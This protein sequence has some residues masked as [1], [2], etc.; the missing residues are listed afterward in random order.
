MSHLAETTRIGNRSRNAGVAIVIVNWRGW[1]DTIECL[2]SVFR[3][4]SEDFRVIVC[5][6][7]SGDG[8]LDAIER[9]AEGH[10]LAK[11]GN[12]E[13]T[14]CSSPPVQKPIRTLRLREGEAS[15]GGAPLVLIEAA[16][17]GG[18]AAG[19]NIGIRSALADETIEF[20]WLLNNDTVVDS[21][22]MRNAVELME[23]Q[24]LTM[25]GS[26]CL[27]YHRPL[28][29]Q[30]LGGLNYD[31]WLGRV[32]VRHGLMRQDVRKGSNPEQVD[33]IA[34]ATWFIRRSAFERI[35]LLD[36]SHFLYFE[37]LDFASRLGSKGSWSYSLESFVYHKAGAS[38]G[39][40]RN[41][42][43]RSTMAEHYLTRGRIIVC[44]RFFPWCLPTTIV[45]IV[46][47]IAYRAIKG[48]FKIAAA[49]MKGLR[50]GLT[51]RLNPPPA[52]ATVKETNQRGFE[53]GALQ[54]ELT[55]D[56]TAP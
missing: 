56:R 53:A 48:R 29:V 44:R 15:G 14:N 47:A 33:F 31:R 34:G 30:S 38:A 54:G 55:P 36:E 2:E 23:K 22:A 5:D 50:E 37:E 13:L 4:R 42:M 11:V 27:F 17:N 28:E 45:T 20:V 35:G 24:Q 19:C 41:R 51:V 26:V 43:A 40:A 25:C 46:I 16:E 3:L 21:D 1:E 10:L 49:M 9:W 7:A 18:F 12:A 32:R 52:L 39:S 8:S 6:N